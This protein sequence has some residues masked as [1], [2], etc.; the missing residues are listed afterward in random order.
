MRVESENNDAVGTEMDRIFLKDIRMRMATIADCI[1]RLEDQIDHGREV[2]AELVRTLM[3]EFHTVKA[4]ADFDHFATLAQIAHAVEDYLILLNRERLIPERRHLDLLYTV[5]DFALQVLAEAGDIPEEFLIQ[6]ANDLI[7]QFTKTVCELREMVSGMREDG[8]DAADSAYISQKPDDLDCLDEQSDGDMV[9]TVKVALDRA[10]QALLVLESGRQGLAGPAGEALAG[11]EQLPRGFRDGMAEPLR[12]LVDELVT[13]L[14]VAVKMQRGPEGCELGILSDVM[15]VIRNCCANLLRGGTGV[16]PGLD[17]LREMVSDVRWQLRVNIPGRGPVPFD[18]DEGTV[19]LRE[20]GEMVRR[21]SAH[22][23]RE[24]GKRVNIELRVDD[25]TIR[26]SCYT[27][28]NEVLVHLVRNAVDHGIEGAEERRAQGKREEGSLLFTAKL[29]AD[30]VL[31]IEVRDDGRGLQR[32]RILAKLG[33]SGA[34]AEA[35]PDITEVIMGA[36]FSTADV[37][38]MYSGRG[39]GMHIVKGTVESLDG[40]ME[41]TSSEGQGMAIR[42]RIPHAG[43]PGAENGPG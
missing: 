20:V 5:V 14:R 35:L 32:D 7:E 25:V 18:E 21:I 26:Q 4:C 36:G 13:V 28:L 29:E 31:T 6:D 23:A 10:K 9:A 19:A 38:T 30:G 34:S 39:M 16:L 1:F 22:A 17:A 2:D 27:R 33:L 15:V 43:K 11:L 42:I 8:V 40:T 24:L 41:V 37:P 12:R 3:R